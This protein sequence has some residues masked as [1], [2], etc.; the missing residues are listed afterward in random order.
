[1]TLWSDSMYSCKLRLFLI[2]IIFFLCIVIV[3]SVSGQGPEKTEADELY[4][5]EPTTEEI[6]LVPLQIK[7]ASF[8]V[9]DLRE[10]PVSIS[11]ISSKELKLSGART[12]S[13]AIMLFTPGFFL[14]EDQD[15][16][17]AGFRGLAPDS[18][19]KVMLLLN[20]NNV[21]TEWFWGPP[22]ALLHSPNFEWIDHI[23]VIRGPGSVTLGQG[24]LLGVIN[25]VTK[26]STGLKSENS[27][28]S[29]IVCESGENGLFSFNLDSS[30]HKSKLFSYFSVFSSHYDGQFLR[31]EGWAH[32]RT[33]EGNSG[34]TVADAGHRLNRRDNLTSW[35]DI[36]LGD[37]RISLLYSDQQKDLYNFYRDRDRYREKI[38]SLSSQ[39]TFTFAED[40]SLLVKAMY[41]RDDF[42][43]SSVTGGTAGGTRENRYNLSMIANLN[44]LFEGNKLALG[45][46]YHRFDFGRKNFNGDNFIINR[47]D[48]ETLGMLSSANEERT[49]GFPDELDIYSVF[50]EDFFTLH[51]GLTLFGAC[52]Y[53]KHPF[54]GEYLSPRLGFR[55]R[56][57]KKQAYRL[58][59]QT[60]FRGAPG[61]HYGGGYKND[62]LLRSSNFDKILEAQIPSG[63]GSF[64]QNIPE[65]EPEEMKSWEFEADLTFDEMWQ[66]N[67]VFFYNIIEKVIDVGVI[68][69]D[70]D[71]YSMPDIGSDIP[72]DWN[73]YWFYKNNEGDI[74][75]YG[76][77]T[78]L[79]YRKNSFSCN[80]SH[81]YVTLDSVS[82]QQQGSMY[83][84]PMK[85][86]S[87]YPENVTRLNL[88][89]ESLSTISTSVNYLYY[90]N[91]YSPQDQKIDGNHLLNLGLLFTLSTKWEFLFMVKNLFDA[92][93]LY[94]MNSNAGDASLSDGTPAVEERTVW[95][96]FRYRLFY[97]SD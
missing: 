26:D 23:E 65:T 83:V 97:E 67:T 88:I 6:G 10:Q 57:G 81:G 12:I 91:W 48:P 95:F 72:G 54:W 43:L 89:W 73:G 70:P 29:G 34:G 38:I 53:D 31:D 45:V 22:D 21:N 18:N 3:V 47:F 82:T 7:V 33:F 66:W 28:Q 96:S 90:H 51:S 37:F 61:V 39:Y 2:F 50:A 92:D 20:G 71:E 11:I 9:S 77:E 63:D 58:S 49:W 14:V 86:I 84:T 35:G 52:R 56:Q 16:V 76:L 55:F 42:A 93:A 17:I 32:A 87:A 15:D 8:V 46:E 5:F 74:K 75:Q 62:G 40:N 80:L 25:I 30:V 41:I 4:F 94:P 60:G 69:A 44:N 19:S 1:M 85:N 13:E 24:A 78:S 79:S 36:S 27:S 68:W 59:Y 64:Y